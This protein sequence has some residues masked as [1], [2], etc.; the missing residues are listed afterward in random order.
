[1]SGVAAD[2]RWAV[3]E[4]QP[5][6][7]E[8]ATGESNSKAVVVGGGWTRRPHA[9]SRGCATGR[10]L[11]RFICKVIAATISLITSHVRPESCRTGE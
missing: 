7:E 9:H 1:V 2:W 6:K 8:E 10:G 11:R 3:P 5:T 4:G